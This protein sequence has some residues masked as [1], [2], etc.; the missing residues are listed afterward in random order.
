MYKE[1]RGM[2]EYE[3]DVALSFAGEDRDVVH[4]IASALKSRSVRVF[5]DE[6]ETSTLWGKDLYQHLSLIY[7]QKARFCVVFASASYAHKAWTKHELKQAQARAF[8]QENEYILPV[9]ID[10]EPIPGISQTIGYVDIRHHGPEGITNLLLMKLGKP[11]VQPHAAVAEEPVYVTYQ[12]FKMV[13]THPARIVEAQT[14]THVLVTRGLERIRYGDEP[15]I[16]EEQ[17]TPKRNCHDCGVLIGQY[18][19]HG[20]DVEVCALCHEQAISCGC[21]HKPV[22]KDQLDR[23]EDGDDGVLTAE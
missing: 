23:W 6:F 21:I 5:Y 22:T 11:I 20:C 1:S 4:S 18:H 13:S 7:Q 14:Q 16:I 10:D 2:T 3:Y 9:R 8:G 12:G 19:T 15:W 17:I